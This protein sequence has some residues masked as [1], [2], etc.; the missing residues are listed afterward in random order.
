MMRRW[1]CLGLLALAACQGGAPAPAGRQGHWAQ[2]QVQ[3]EDKPVAW[4]WQTDY[5]VAPPR[6]QLLVTS[7]HYTTPRADGLPE[8]AMETRFADVEA[9]LLQTVGAHGSLVATMSYDSQ[10]DWYFYVD[11]RSLDVPVKKLFEQA[12][13]TDVVVSV[14]DDAAAAFYSAL[15]KKLK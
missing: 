10:H 2:V 5:T 7:L 1:C 9:Q 11:D 15:Q 8:A 13:N 14:E 12:R 6:T 4:Q 3:R